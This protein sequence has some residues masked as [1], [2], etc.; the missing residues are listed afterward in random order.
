MVE[1]VLFWR[2][3][4]YFQNFLVLEMDLTKSWDYDKIEIYYIFIG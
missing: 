3:T 1:S 4:K 2:D